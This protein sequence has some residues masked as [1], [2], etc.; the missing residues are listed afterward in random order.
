M[1]GMGAKSGFLRSYWWGFWFIQQQP[2]RKEIHA[3]WWVSCLYNN[4]ASKQYVI[5]YG[6]QRPYDQVAI[7][8]VGRVPV[9]SC[10]TGCCTVIHHVSSLAYIKVDPCDTPDGLLC[11]FGLMHLRAEEEDLCMV[12]IGLINGNDSACK[13][14]AC[15][16]LLL[17]LLYTFVSVGTATV[18]S[19]RQ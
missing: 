19:Y 16:T 4:D 9:Q 1:K 10:S 8:A 7:P 14:Q 3:Y 2:M 17:L 11:G 6:M 18:A 5:A 13:V 12:R 15:K